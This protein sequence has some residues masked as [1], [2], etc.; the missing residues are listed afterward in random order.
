MTSGIIIA[1]LLQL[2][3]IVR[4]FVKKFNTLNIT[5]MSKPVCKY[6]GH[7]LEPNYPLCRN[8]GMPADSNFVGA[9]DDEADDFET[10]VEVTDLNPS[11]APAGIPVIPEHEPPKDGKKHIRGW[12]LL[13]V[14]LLFLG[15]AR[16]IIEIIRTNM[17]LDTTIVVSSL[18]LAGLAIITGVAL[19]RHQK[20]AIFLARSYVVISSIASLLTL[21]ILAAVDWAFDAAFLLGSLLGIIGVMVIWLLFFSKSKQVKEDYEKKHTAFDWVL[22]IVAA[23]FIFVPLVMGINKVFNGPDPSSQI[24]E[25]SLEIYDDS[26]WTD[27]DTVVIPD[28]P[29]DSVPVF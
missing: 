25:E 6:C 8:C 16:T 13:F 1:F 22:V 5:I 29:D 21:P 7:D 3:E 14:I 9:G 27:V 10:E 23:L 28:N 4:K 18:I 2:S 17:L 12:L 26:G 19:I 24:P 11:V 15:A 20:N